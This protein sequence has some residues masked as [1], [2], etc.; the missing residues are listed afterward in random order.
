MLCCE[1]NTNVNPQSGLLPPLG[2][3]IPV[4]S[5]VTGTVYKAVLSNVV[6]A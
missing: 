2:N 4:E 6:F 3:I 1:Q 5:L